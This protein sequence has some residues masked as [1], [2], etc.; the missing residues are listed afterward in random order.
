MMIQNTAVLWNSSRKEVCYN[1]IL[2][3]VSKMSRS[4]N[5]IFSGLILITIGF[6]LLL[7]SGNI[8][9]EGFVF[10]FPFFFAGGNLSTVS[11]LIPLMLIPLA[12]IMYFWW[13]RYTKLEGDI[14]AYRDKEMIQC[15]MCKKM[16]LKNSTYCQH[17]GSVVSGTRASEE[18]DDT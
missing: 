2:R 6:I 14:F 16:I 8:E 1:R 9:T 12:I 4:M 10:I 13:F 15:P 11:I 17:C 7:L 18:W 3:I 5:W